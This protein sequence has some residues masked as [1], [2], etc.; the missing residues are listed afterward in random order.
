MAPKPKDIFNK[1]RDFRAKNEKNLIVI[2]L[3]INSVR[4]KFESLKTLVCNNL[5]II[6]VA[7]TKLDSTLT[8]S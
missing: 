6:T 3:N 1:L 2:Y 5:D 4:N 7:E 8:T